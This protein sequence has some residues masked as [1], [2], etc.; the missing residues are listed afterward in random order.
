MM[1]SKMTNMNSD[2]WHG[3]A[4]GEAKR[5][6]PNGKYDFFWIV[7]ESGMRG[8]TLRLD[9]E[10]DTKL[11]LPR[12]KNLQLSIRKLNGKPAFVIGLNESAQTEIFETLC[13]DVEQAGEAGSDLNEAFA[14]SLRR[15]RRWY[16]LL[17][18]GKLQGLSIEEQRGLVGE[19]SFLRQLISLL[20]A[21]AAIEAWTGPTGSAKDFEL[22]GACVEVKTRRGGAT[23]F[24][25]I[26]S[27]EQLADVVASRLFLHVVSVESG[28]APDGY[29][30]HDHVESTSQ[31]LGDADTAW[32]K[33]EE[34]LEMT[35]YDSENPYE[36]RRW[37]LI[38]SADYEVIEG[39]PRISTPLPAGVEK[40][41]YALSLDAC[42]AFLFQGNLSDIIS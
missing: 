30:L 15:T 29:S 3:L 32:D 14:R 9:S 34:R 5:V 35:G 12:L 2:P 1:I 11:P 36:D 37:L 24:V 41:R 28:I 25:S 40:V 33:W 10:S 21:E 8:F 13:R 4:E 22:M 31:L 19:L 7:L 17:R 26:S 38:N 27:A 18:G 20:G 6:S 39:F 16:H 42:E 23:S